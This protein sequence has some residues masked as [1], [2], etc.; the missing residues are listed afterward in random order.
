MLYIA[1]LLFV[2]GVIIITVFF[3]SE[4]KNFLLTRPSTIRGAA[5]GTIGLV[6]T[7][8]TVGV[9]GIARPRSRI[10]G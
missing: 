1:I 7:I 3:K 8:G 6:V 5:G 10:A 2:I 4:K 9:V